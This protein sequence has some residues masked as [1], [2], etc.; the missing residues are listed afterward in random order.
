MAKPADYIACSSCFASFPAWIEQLIAES[1]GNKKTDTCPNCGSTEGTKLTRDQLIELAH[2]FFV[3]GSFRRV[4]YGGA[5]LIQF[6][7][8]RSIGEVKFPCPLSDDAALIERTCGIG[9]FHYAPRLWMLGEVEPLQRIQDPSTRKEIVSRIVS[10]YPSEILEPSQ[11]FYRVRK[12]VGQPENRDEYDS[13]PVG[14][15][16]TGRLD[17]PE[18]PVL[19]ASPLIDVCVHESRFTAE[20]ELYVA[21]LHASRPLSLLNLWTSQLFIDT[22]RSS[23]E[24]RSNASGLT[25]PIWL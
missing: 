16:S 25:P 10:E 9:F 5:P 12:D 3:W 14:I 22:Y 19:Y 24:A 2:R 15:A 17:A 21:T 11:R 7:D 13:P 1:L 23:F 20:D 4:E 6:N 8:Q 18:F